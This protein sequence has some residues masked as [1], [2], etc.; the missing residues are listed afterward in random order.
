MTSATSCAIEQFKPWFQFHAVHANL[1]GALVVGALALLLLSIL[2]SCA[3]ASQ[4]RAELPVHINACKSLLVGQ[5]ISPLLS[6]SAAEAMLNYKERHWLF[7]DQ[8][9]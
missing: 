8:S 9:S 7:A 2:M 1:P 3:Q 4:T 6:Q 5:D